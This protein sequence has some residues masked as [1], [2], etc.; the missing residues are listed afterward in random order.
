[1]NRIAENLK[2][3]SLLDFVQQEAARLTISSMPAVP[4]VLPWK[5]S[6]S[7]CHAWML[8][9]MVESILRH[10]GFPDCFGHYIIKTY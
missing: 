7:S 9:R 10:D 4:W 5:K 6:D 8:L 3:Q 2:S 1:M